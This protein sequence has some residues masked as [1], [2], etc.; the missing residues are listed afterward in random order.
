LLLVLE[1]LVEQPPFN[2]EPTASLF[3]L[4]PRRELMKVRRNGRRAASQQLWAKEIRQ[5]SI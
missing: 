2:V 4:S 3:S 1:L 5:K